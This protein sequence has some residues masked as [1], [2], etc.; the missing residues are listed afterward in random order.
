MKLKTMPLFILLQNKNMHFPGQIS[1]QKAGF[2]VTRYPLGC[3]QKQQVKRLNVDQVWIFRSK[4]TSI[5][6][7]NPKKLNLNKLLKT[8]AGNFIIKKKV[9]T[10]QSELS[11]GPDPA[12]LFTLK[13]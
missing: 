8:P 3:F 9:G 5:L 4:K 10:P 6:E 11:L 13:V 12:Q 1:V 2:L 7:S